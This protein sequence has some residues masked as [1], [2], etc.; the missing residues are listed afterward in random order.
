MFQDS[1]TSISLKLR[2]YMGRNHLLIN[3]ILDLNLRPCSINQWLELAQRLGIFITTFL[4]VAYERKKFGSG[5]HAILAEDT[6]TYVRALS[7]DK[8]LD[9]NANADLQYFIISPEVEHNRQVI[10]EWM[11]PVWTRRVL[12]F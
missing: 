2:C 8:R 6:V 10:R 7:G 5:H 12:G 9:C 3:S 4:A 1:A 11:G